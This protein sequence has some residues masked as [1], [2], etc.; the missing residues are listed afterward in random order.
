MTKNPDDRLNVLLQENAEIN[1]LLQEHV[2][3]GLTNLHRPLEQFGVLLSRPSFILTALLGFLAW[4]ALNLE[5]KWTHH[6]P[7]DQPP[8]YWLQGLVGLL[9][10]LVTVTVLVG[11]ARQ[12][13]LAEQRAQLQLQIV[14]LIE[15]RS[16]KTIAL[17][18]ELRRDLPNVHNRL[19]EDAIAMQQSSD[20]Q[21]ILEAINTLENGGA[22]SL[23][24]GDKAGPAS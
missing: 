13:Q 18:E 1:A 9:S 7:W 17:L 5:L 10:L 24:P 14:L 16:A 23:P 11:Q 8:F 4:I 2:E 19:D 22:T 15:Q 20:P 6:T 12:G 21:A 3:S